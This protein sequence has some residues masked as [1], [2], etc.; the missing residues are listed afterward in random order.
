MAAKSQSIGQRLKEL[1][2]SRDMTQNDL[3]EKLFVSSKTISKWEKDGSV[4]ETDTLVQIGELFNV[5]LDYLLTGKK[6]LKEIDAISKIELACREDNI[7]LLKDIDIESF[8]STGKDVRYYVKKYNA[9]NVR[10]YLIDYKTKNYVS[11]HDYKLP[12]R[13]VICAFPKGT[14]NEEDLELIGWNGSYGKIAEQC[15]KYENVGYH[16]FRVFREMDTYE[17]M[18][19]D[20]SYFYCK[21]LDKNG[22]KRISFAV[23]LLDDAQS[24]FL[25]MIVWREKTY[26]LNKTI[27]GKLVPDYHPQ[28][29]Q[30]TEAFAYVKPTVMKEFM[31]L[32]TEL[33]IKNWEHRHY[34][35]AICD[36]IYYLKDVCIDDDSKCKKF[37]IAP[38]IEK[39]KKL[40]RA[41]EKICFESLKR[42]HY[43]S[44]VNVFN[45]EYDPYCREGLDFYTSKRIFSEIEHEKEVIKTGGAMPPGEF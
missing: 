45:N 18:P 39:Y 29:D 13:Y 7:A 42:R 37:Y 38:G 41:I 25:H 9:K 22:N 20:Y 33:D 35:A 30:E 31:D 43:K 28:E 15:A 40:T 44:F 24:G 21:L 26:L 23:S 4:P 3:A 11:A 12:K 1:R 17:K 2:Q 10:R 19:K 6:N 34:G 32:L 27:D 16:G 14:N 36:V 8:D 5:T